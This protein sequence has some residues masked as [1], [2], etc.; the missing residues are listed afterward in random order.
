LVLGS[1]GRGSF[2]RLLMGSTAHTVLRSLPCPT[3]ITRVR[4]AK[5]TG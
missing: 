1:R 5:L 2:K 3:V 4:R